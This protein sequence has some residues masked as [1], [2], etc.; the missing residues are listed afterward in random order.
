MSAL[1]ASPER[2]RPM[3]ISIVTVCYN[4][5]TVID[6]CLTS[7]AEQTYRDF[8]HIVIDG[9]STDATIAIVQRYPHVTACV[10]EPD[11][12]IYDAM[13]KGLDRVTGDYVL[14]LNAD[15]A[16]ES[17]TTLARAVTAIDRDPGADVYY[18]WLEVRP[19]DGPPQ[20]F[21]PPPPAEAPEFMV[22]GCLPHQ[23]TLARPS[24]FART[25][26]F[27][28]RYRCHADYDWFLK[29]LAD[30]GIDVRSISE[31]I[32]SFRLGGASS[33]LAEGQPE[34]YRI[35]NQSPLYEK[36]E[37]DKKRIEALQEAFLR[38]RLETARLRDAL[39][40]ATEQTRSIKSMEVKV[41]PVYRTLMAGR[42]RRFPG[43]GRAAVRQMRDI[44]VSQRQRLRWWFLETLVRLLPERAIDVL[45][46]LREYR[47]AMRTRRYVSGLIRQDLPSVLDERPKLA[48]IDEDH[49]HLVEIPKPHA[50]NCIADR[51]T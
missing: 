28:L 18:G 30:P 10:S 24:V 46:R 26:R 25:G 15:D 13:N 51:E 7:V 5:A 14:F 20:V 38:E 48:D 35:Q 34:V 33:Q 49:K 32:G 16:F 11:Q 17:A 40:S 3:K 37:W 27:D 29:I 41:D 2:D 12:G 9:L 43:A 22:C 42:W 36:P 19:L 6:G 8:E 44:A 31:V 23:S 47:R 1:L 50:R 45:R 21:Q 4:A 39:R